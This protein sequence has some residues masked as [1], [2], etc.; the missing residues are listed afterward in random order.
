MPDVSN[1]TCLKTQI[2]LMY[3]FSGGGG[4]LSQH[5]LFLTKKKLEASSYSYY[6]AGISFQS[7]T[8]RS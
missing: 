2:L 6:N 7:I 4:T 3:S 5:V 1:G 8:D